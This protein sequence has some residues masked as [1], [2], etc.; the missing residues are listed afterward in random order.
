M[1]RAALLWI[2]ALLL[3]TAGLGYDRARA[4]GREPAAAAEASQDPS[5]LA[6]ADVGSRADAVGAR[7]RAMGEDVATYAD[8]VSRL[9]NGIVV[10]RH[11]IA[12]R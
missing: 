11:R 9:E 2:G 1:R 4:E 3:G 12:D 8:I 10:Y 6:F 7:L 5:P